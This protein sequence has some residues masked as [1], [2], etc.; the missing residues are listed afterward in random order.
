M[1]FLNAE[2]EAKRLGLL[3]ELMPK[4]VRVAVLWNPA[5]DE[6]GS[7]TELQ[8]LQEAARTVGLQ[9]RILNATTI[10]E[11]D[12]PLSHLHASA[13]TPSLSPVAGPTRQP[14]QPEATGAVMEVTKWLKPSDSWSR[15]TVTARVCGLQ[16]K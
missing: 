10:G 13:P 4:A 14:L 3:H 8:D 5:G 9:I 16:R 2:L 7:S 12:A 15:Y 1:N 11:I 6:P